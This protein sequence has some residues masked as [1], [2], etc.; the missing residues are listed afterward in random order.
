LAHDHVIVAAMKS[1][2]DD[3]HGGERIT[4]SALVPIADLDAV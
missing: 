1:F 4:N 2:D 3:R